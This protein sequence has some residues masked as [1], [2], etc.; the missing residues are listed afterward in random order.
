VAIGLALAGCYSPSFGE[1]GACTSVCPGDL[2]CVNGICRDPGYQVDAAVDA[3]P[4]S[5]PGDSDGD[6]IL[7]DV[8]NCAAA[9]NADQHDEDSDA[10]GDACDPCPHLGGTASDVDGDGVGDACD[11]DPSVAK[12]HIKFFDPFTTSQPEWQHGTGVTRLT[13]QLRAMP[14][15]GSTRLGVPTGELRIIAGGSVTA[16]SSTTPHMMQIAFGLN[17][18]GDDYYYAQFYDASGSGGSVDLAK[19]DSGVFTVLAGA[20]YGGK[21]PT[22][23]WSMQIDESV[24]AQTLGLTARV[25]GLAY[26]PFAT[27]A[28]TPALISNAE[29]GIYTRNVDVRVDYML[30]IE[31]T[32]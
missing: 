28:S 22:G 23:A 10:I 21:L 4:D 9:S 17:T 6:G 26:G 24:S 1:G 29:V 7:D 8:D 13:D 5:P 16:V 2:K 14:P 25:G 18:A 15:T 32:P 31:T 3:T 27:A 19:A 12:Q 20:S 11:P 30:I